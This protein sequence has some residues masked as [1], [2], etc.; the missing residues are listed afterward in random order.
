MSDYA[1]YEY[2]GRPWWRRWLLRLLALLALAGVTYGVVKIVEEGTKESDSASIIAPALKRLATAQEE[3]GK[4]VAG[5]KPGRPPKGVARAARRAESARQAAVS[6][7]RKR[8]AAGG[9]VPDEGKLQAALGAEF[10]YLDAIRSVL[11]NR[12]SPLLGSVGDRAQTA[13]DAFTDLPD[14]EGV[15]DGIRGTQ[16]LIA[17]AKARR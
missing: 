12:L 4:R 7:L 11:R 13:L 6:A 9:S 14:S 8:Q 1:G 17:W 16:A 2:V 10:D 5:L 15:E 3:L